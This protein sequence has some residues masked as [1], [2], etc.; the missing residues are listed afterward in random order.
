MQL[1]VRNDDSVAVYRLATDP[2]LAESS[3]ATRVKA[4]AY[5]VGKFGFDK[6]PSLA[7]ELYL[8]A[9]SLGDRDSAFYAGVLYL[10][11]SNP[12]YDLK[13]GNQLIVEAATKG[14]EPAQRVAAI[15]YLDS[16][17]DNGLKIDDIDNWFTDDS[18]YFHPKANATLKAALSLHSMKNK[19]SSTFGILQTY[20]EIFEEDEDYNASTSYLPA[21]FATNISFEQFEHWLEI[22]VAEK[23]SKA[24][25]VLSAICYLETGMC[26]DKTRAKELGEMAVTWSPDLS[27]EMS[28]I[29][30]MVK[31]SDAQYD[32]FQAFGAQ[33]SKALSGDLES[34]LRMHFAFKKGVPSLSISPHSELA[35]EWYSVLEKAQPSAVFE[36]YRI[37]KRIISMVSD[38]THFLAGGISDGRIADTLLDIAIQKE[39]PDALLENATKFLKDEQYDSVFAAN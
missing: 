10:Q 37:K 1:A 18:A 33:L 26:N 4:Y 6:N 2:L 7:L 3:Y 8:K 19:L 38:D 21:W 14:S 11:E 36:K 29:I 13:L 12:F 5:E 27:S 32:L 25:L 39:Y 23:H 20:S 24:A 31:P 30:D 34:A 9:N 16:D 22:G 17:C 35:D 28:F 15:C